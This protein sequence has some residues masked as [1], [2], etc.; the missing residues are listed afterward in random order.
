MVLESYQLATDQMNHVVSARSHSWN[1]K[2]TLCLVFTATRNPKEKM[3]SFLERWV[4]VVEGI[5]E[6]KYQ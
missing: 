6:G 4:G 1:D 2:L 5:Y 3:Q